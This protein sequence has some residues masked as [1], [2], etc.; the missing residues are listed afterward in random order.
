MERGDTAADAIAIGA[1][2]LYDP[3]TLPAAMAMTIDRVTS[4]IRI[5]ASGVDALEPVEGGGHVDRGRVEHRQAVVG[6]VG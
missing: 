6:G 4:P 1:G 5:R 3:W 2:E